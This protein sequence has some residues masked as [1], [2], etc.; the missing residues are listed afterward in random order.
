MGEE[1][2]RSRGV[3]KE[4]EGNVELVGNETAWVDRPSQPANLLLMNGLPERF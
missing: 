2:R 3:P 1:K 4:Q